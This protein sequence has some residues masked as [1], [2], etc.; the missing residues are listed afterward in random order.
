CARGFTAWRIGFD[1]W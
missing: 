1:Y